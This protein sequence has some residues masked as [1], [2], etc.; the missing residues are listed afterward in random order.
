MGFRVQEGNQVI[1]LSLLITTLLELVVRDIPT[2]LQGS[3]SRELLSLRLLTSP[4]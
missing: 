2:T 1:I 4:P 3:A